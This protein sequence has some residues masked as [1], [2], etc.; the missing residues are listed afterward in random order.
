MSVQCLTPDLTEARRFLATLDPEPGAQFGFA[1]FDDRGGDPRLA[2]R[3]FGDLDRSVRLTGRKR[4]Q[5]CS[6]VGLLCFMQHLGA[7]VFAT[8]QHLDGGGAAARNVDRIRALIADA[9]S[10]EQLARL[11]RFVDGSGL[12]PSIVV[13][14]GGLTA[15]GAEKRQSYWLLA[16]CAVAAF[17]RLQALLLSRIGTDGTVRDPRA[18]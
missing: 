6:T 17:P 15:S 12:A 4:G 8:V 1:T 5:V 2:L 11:E 10:D 7:G 13:A 14:S 18:Y 9:D 16:D 3:L